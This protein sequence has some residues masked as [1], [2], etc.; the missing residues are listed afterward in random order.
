MRGSSDA[1]L[2]SASRGDLTAGVAIPL[3]I[4]RSTV[5]GPHVTLQTVKKLTLAVF[6]V[7]L[8]LSF[9][10]DPSG[11]AES[12]S[13]FV[14]GVGGFFATAIDKGAEFVTSLG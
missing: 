7:F 14:A 12:F 3:A 6:A 1:L 13:D 2:R 5:G 4:R 8:L 9:W 10:N 11:S